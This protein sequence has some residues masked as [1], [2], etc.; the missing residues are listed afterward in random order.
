MKHKV[1][2]VVMAIFLLGLVSLLSA[3]GKSEPAQQ[4]VDTTPVQATEETIELNGDYAIDISDLGMA[5][6]FYLRIG[7]DNSFLLSA[8]RQFSDN[9]GSGTIGELDGTYLM[10]FSDST[11]ERPKTATFERVGPNLIFRS[12]LPYGSANISFEKVDDHNPEIVYH[13]TAD[14]YV[15]EE[16]YD[17]YLG[18]ESVDGANYNYVLEL[19][20]GA[21]Y[22]FVS[23]YQ[24]GVEVAEY[25]ERGSFK[26]SGESIVIIPEGEEERSGSILEQGALVLNVQPKSTSERSNSVFRVAT[27]A[28]HTGTW[29]AQNEESAAMLELDYFGG[30]AFTSDDMF[31]AEAG[32]FE[33]SQGTISFIK[34]GQEQAT[35][36]TK[37]A[38]TLQASFNDVDWIFYADAIQGHFTGG[39]M[40]NEAFVAELDL[41]SDGSYVLEIIDNESELTLVG[42]AGVFSIKAGPMS[43]ILTLS[44]ED[45]VRA[46]D[47]WPTGLNMTFDIDGTNYSFLLMK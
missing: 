37:E 9:R 45:R 2:R 19:G 25:K 6:K 13:L 30:Y 3:C 20:P 34:E 28:E 39:T 8:N 17:T 24:D 10:I 36:G 7:E 12:A 32:S 42:E 38:Y 14:K 26:V 44:S 15:Y 27:T 11:Q 47:I 5:L 21:K 16:Y 33:V 43:Y 46:G 22:Q 35:S 4:V 1:M 40:V 23:S 41:S 29:Y 31:Y 18:F